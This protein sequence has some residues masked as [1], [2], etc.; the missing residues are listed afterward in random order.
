M[1]KLVAILFSAV[2]MF[3]ISFG[4]AHAAAKNLG[5]TA[6][7]FIQKYNASVESYGITSLRIGT[8]KNKT[9]DVLSTFQYM[10]TPNIAIIGT[11][12]TADGLMREVCILSTPTTEGEAMMA[13][14]AFSGITLILNPNLTSAER[15]NLMRNLNLYDGRIENL[16]YGKGEAIAGNVKYTTQLVNN[17]FSFIASAKDL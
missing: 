15:E 17:I 7:Q 11:M 14:A 13:L 12:G 6:N 10:F 2:L 9:G 5:M 3:S 16:Q 1:K 4:E 8:T